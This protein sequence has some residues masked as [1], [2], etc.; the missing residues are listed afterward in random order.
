[1]IREFLAETGAFSLI[2]FM[3]DKLGDGKGAILFDDI[4]KLPIFLPVGVD[5]DQELIRLLFF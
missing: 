4:P 3:T 1:M 2:F 5:L